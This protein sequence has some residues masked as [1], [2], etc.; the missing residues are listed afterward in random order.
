LREG[1]GLRHALRLTVI[2][3]VALAH[4][5]SVE[6]VVETSL[7]AGARAVQ[8]REKG[9]SAVELLTRA[10]R[11]RALTRQWGAYL[12]INDRFD[13]ALAAEA[14]GVHLGP[15]DLPVEAVRRA[16]PEGFII[17]HSTDKFSAALEAQAN[18]ADYIGCGAV[19]STSTKL[20]AGEAIGVEGLDRI[21]RAVGIPVVGI[22]GI[23][24]IR[25]QAVAAGSAAAGV[26]V[27]GAIMGAEDVGGAIRELLAPFQTREP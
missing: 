9:A 7:A 16:A 11:L 23:N 26:A 19:F 10:Q 20:D 25:A 12:I 27:V 24:A 3:D 8:L 13:V 5:K 21:A 2:T 15:H 18:G 17:G 1:I 22:G 4:P 6:E 14:D